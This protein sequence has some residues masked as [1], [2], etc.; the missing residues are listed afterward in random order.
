MKQIYVQEFTK[1]FAAMIS[2]KY[3]NS[4]IKRNYERWKHK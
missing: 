2:R 3:F 4:D 1:A